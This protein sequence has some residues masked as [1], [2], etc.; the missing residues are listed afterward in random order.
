[1]LEV[2]PNDAEGNIK[3]VLR[4]SETLGV[5]V[6]LH[7]SEIRRSHGPDRLALLTYLHQLRA[8]FT[9]RQFRLSR[10]GMFWYNLKL[11]QS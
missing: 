8:L 11:N 6:L 7:P 1:M 4:A 2:S 10:I 3:M 9:N 5:P